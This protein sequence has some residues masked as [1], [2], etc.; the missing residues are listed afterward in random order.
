MTT[1]RTLIAVAASSSWTISQ[2][3]VK[4]AF[5]NGDPHEEVYM[6]QVQKSHHN[7]VLES[8]GNHE[9]Q[10]ELYTSQWNHRI[11]F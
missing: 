4:N 1:V 11:L 7:Q 5:L 10:D 9:P 2:M 8:V 6:Q 3:D